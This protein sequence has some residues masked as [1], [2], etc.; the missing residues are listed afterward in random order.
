MGLGIEL[1]NAYYPP[2]SVNGEEMGERVVTSLI[3]SALGNLLPEFWPD[4]K[5]KLPH[6]RH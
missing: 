3:A 2:K 5:A 1:S 6:Y 4:F